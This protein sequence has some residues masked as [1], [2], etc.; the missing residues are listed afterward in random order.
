MHTFKVAIRN[1]HALN[2]TLTDVSLDFNDMIPYVSLPVLPT[3]SPTL[4]L[5]WSVTLVSSRQGSLTMAV[6]PTSIQE[7]PSYRPTPTLGRL[8][9]VVR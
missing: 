1:S 9:E 7:T 5:S 4:L 3:P 8:L 2:K 6:Q